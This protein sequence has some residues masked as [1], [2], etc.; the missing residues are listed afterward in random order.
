MIL[1]KMKTM[2]GA[3]PLM[4]NNEDFEDLFPLELWSGPC[5]S[6]VHSPVQLHEGQAQAQLCPIHALLALP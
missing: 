5:Y 4:C 2:T 1:T 6:Y 3:R